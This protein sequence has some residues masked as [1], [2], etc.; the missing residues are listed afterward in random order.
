MHSIFHLLP[1]PGGA[2]DE[3]GMPLGDPMA[4]LLECEAVAMD[5]HGMATCGWFRI[6]GVRARTRSSC[7]PLSRIEKQMCARYTVRGWS[8]PLN[9]VVLETNLCYSARCT[10]DTGEGIM[11]AWKLLMLLD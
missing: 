9:V 1:Y 3:A 8:R 7:T 10:V 4:R 6:E 2:D 11:N 5:P